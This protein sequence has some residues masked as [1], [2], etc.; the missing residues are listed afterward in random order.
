MAEDT[1]KQY[2]IKEAVSLTGV[3]LH[4]GKKVKLTFKPAS[5][6]HGYAFKRTDIEE[7][8]VIQAKASNVTT[9]DRGTRLES[10]GVAIQT[11]E[12]VLA[13]CVGLEIDNL[14][15]EINSEE[16]PIMDGS[17]KIFVEALEKAGREEQEAE[18]EVYEVDEVISY[19]DKDSG[20]EITIIPSDRYEVLTM[21]DFNTEV[22]GT[23]NAVLKD[24]SDFKTEIA[25][26]RT[27]SF[28]HELE[29][30]LDSGL[31]RGGDLDNAI[32]YVNKEISEET[33]E[34]LKKVFNK[35]EVSIRPNGI[36]DNVKLHYQNEAARHKLLEVGS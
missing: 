22:L 36:L 32:V 2:T 19:R 18:R 33:T 17:S 23:Q 30:L 11:C 31:I 7:S 9:T 28:L 27:F 3:G 16:P 24:L 35:S 14:L 29:P 21:V 10:N 13:A 20:S 12:H 34:K 1:N 6:N 15:I 5:E 26:A 25:N 8:P 4:T